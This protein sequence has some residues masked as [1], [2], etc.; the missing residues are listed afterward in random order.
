MNLFFFSNT[1]GDTFFDGELMTNLTL[2]RPMTDHCES[3]E[4]S[5]KFDLVETIFD[6][7]QA[8]LFDP[9]FNIRDCLF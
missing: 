7:I 8:F 6:H 9:F 4:D 2:T 3:D 1:Y 5:I